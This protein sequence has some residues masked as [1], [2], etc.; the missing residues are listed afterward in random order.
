MSYYQSDIVTTYDPSS[1]CITLSDT[2]YIGMRVRFSYP[3]YSYG[4]ENGVEKL[5]LNSVYVVQDYMIYTDGV[6]FVLTKFPGVKFDSRLFTLENNTY[7]IPY[8]RRRS[9]F[10]IEKLK[11]RARLWWC[12]S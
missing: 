8:G 6:S 7:I 9:R 10:F 1:R 2:L 12:R 3:D 4:G 11:L 5:T